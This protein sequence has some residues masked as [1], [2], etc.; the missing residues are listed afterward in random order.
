MRKLIGETY[1]EIDDTMRKAIE[2]IIEKPDH[3]ACL[4]EPDLAGVDD[5]IRC[6]VVMID[7][8]TFQKIRKLL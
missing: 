1:I 8:E 4:I 3:Y 7:D 6:R 2:K 5:H